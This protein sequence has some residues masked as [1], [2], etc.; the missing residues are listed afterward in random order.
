LLQ[1]TLDEFCHAVH[2]RL[3]WSVSVVTFDDR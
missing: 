3:S 1:L 2:G